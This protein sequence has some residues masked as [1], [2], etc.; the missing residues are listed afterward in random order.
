MAYQASSSMVGFSTWLVRGVGA[1]LITFVV[2]TFVFTKG[3]EYLTTILPAF[4]PST[5]FMGLPSAFIFGLAYLDGAFVLSTLMGGEAT[6]F[7]IRR[8]KV[9]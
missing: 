5:I 4:D 2:L 7:L 9:V 8:I 6:A 1:K 3:F